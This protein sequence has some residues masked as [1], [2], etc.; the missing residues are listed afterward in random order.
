[1]NSILDI[2][3]LE[4]SDSPCDKFENCSACDRVG[5]NTESKA[6]KQCIFCDYL[7]IH[8]NTTYKKEHN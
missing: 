7:I 8:D 1:M 4:F 2:E 6:H 5:L 3:P